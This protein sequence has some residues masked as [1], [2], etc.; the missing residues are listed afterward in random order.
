[1]VGAFWNSDEGYILFDGRNI[2]EMKFSERKEVRKEIGMLFQGTAL[3]DSLSVQ[4]NVMFPLDMF[5]TMTAAE[6]LK[7]VNFCL[8]RVNLP[9][10]NK[11]YPG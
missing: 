10:T 2:T 5:T 11:K 1:M 7:R 8:E 6:K 3:F 4:E 9:N